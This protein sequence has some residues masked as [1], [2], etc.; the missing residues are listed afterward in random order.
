MPTYAPSVSLLDWEYNF[1][2]L[3][4]GGD[5]DYPLILVQGYDPPDKRVDDTQYSGRDGSLVFADYYDKR[6]LTFQGTLE[7]DQESGDFDNKL[8]LL[9]LAL[10]TPQ[11]IAIPV[12]SSLPGQVPRNVFVKPTKFDYDVD[13][14]Y[15]IGYCTWTWQ[16]EAGDPTIYS[17]TQYNVELLPPSPSGFTFNIRFPLNFG[18]GGASAGVALN[19]GTYKSFPQVHVTGSCV[20]PQLISLRQ[21]RTLKFNVTLGPSDYLD[22]DFANK[23]VMFDGALWYSLLDPSSQWWYIQPGYNTLKL[24]AS[25]ATGSCKATVGYWSAWI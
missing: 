3:T 17:A 4:F 13:L 8:N 1:N 20:N 16:A 11:P 21:N 24:I 25:G 22:I 5:T 6:V 2:G 9:K 23:I 14:N 19:A 12:Q 10:D 7:A 15:S 18:G